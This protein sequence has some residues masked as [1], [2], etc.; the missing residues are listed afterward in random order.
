M[1]P[2]KVRRTSIKSDKKSR[3][4]NL[5]LLKLVTKIVN[6]S[7]RRALQEFHTNRTMFHYSGGPPSL[8]IDY[9]NA[10]RESIADRLWLAPNAFEVADK[11]Y[12][13]T[14]DKFNNLPGKNESSPKAEKIT[15]LNMKRKGADCRLYFKAFLKR[16]A[17]P[18]AKESPASQIEKE[19]RAAHIMQGLVK[20]QFYR[21]LL[22]AE[23]NANPFWSRYNW[24]VNGGTICVWLP[25]SL[26]GRKRQKWL[27]KN[28]DDPD[29]EREG[30]SERIQ[31][32]IDSNLVRERFV[33]LSKDTDDSKEEELIPVSNSNETIELSLYEEVAEEK[34][35]TLPKQR[36]S[37]RALGE[38]KLKHL[39]LRIFEDLS[40]DRYEDKRVARDFGLSKATFSRFAGSRW[41]S[42]KSGIPDLWRN[43]AEIISK[44]ETFKEAAKSAGVWEQVETA[45]R[46]GERGRLP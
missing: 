30:E 1:S 19:T 10:L 29:P 31:S 27:E 8:F 11:A 15:K 4:R 2:S 13:L 26:A 9:L 39:I 22:E 25:V 20:R 41:L 21:S 45:L 6:K 24:R 43:T 3:Y 16:A 42:V 23:R 33:S 34:I 18:F 5:P 32:I 44:N 12:D 40:N 17:G 14:I 37:I 46:G 38:R 36:R 7:D 28:I 35:R